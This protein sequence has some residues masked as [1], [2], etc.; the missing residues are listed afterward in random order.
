M[1]NRIADM[2]LRKAAIVAGLGLLAMTPPAIFTNFFVLQGLVAPGDAAQ[3]AANIMAN[4]LLFRLGIGCFIIVIILDVLV[5][6]GLWV[7]LRPVSRSVSLL[8]AWFRLLYTAVFAVALLY[9]AIPLR[10]LSG[11]EYLSALGTELLYAQALLSL[12]SFTDGWAIGYACFFGLHLFLLGYLVLKSDYVPR[13]LGVLLIISSLAYL[14]DNS[15][16][17]IAPGYEDYQAITSMVVF[18]PA[19]I[20]EFAFMLWLLFRGGRTPSKDADSA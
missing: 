12:D 6:W 8:A 4:E 18:L 9:L 11:A 1:T 10:F 17:L 14:I 16:Q 3:T 20:G 19:F 13:L 7:F 15:A 2:S 5:A